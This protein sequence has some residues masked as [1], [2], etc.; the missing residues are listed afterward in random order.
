M[1]SLARV[2]AV[3]T[4][5]MT[6]SDCPVFL[7]FAEGQLRVISV[8]EQCVQKWVLRVLDW[9]LEHGPPDFDIECIEEPHTYIYRTQLKSTGDGVSFPEGVGD[10]V[11]SPEGVVASSSGV[12]T[13][14]DAVASPSVAAHRVDA[15]V[16]WDSRVALSDA[17]RGN[18]SMAWVPLTRWQARR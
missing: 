17:P 14:S 13:R 1:A 5:P 11:S 2:L 8:D 4:E 18:S 12:A 7:G 15:R 10:G 3:S 6:V 9:I 16:H